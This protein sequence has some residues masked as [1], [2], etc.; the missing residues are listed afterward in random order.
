MTCPAQ[1]NNV[2]IHNAVQ[3][4]S[5]LINFFTFGHITAAIFTVLIGLAQ[6]VQSCDVVVK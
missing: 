2:F 1:R 3:K 5:Y 6:T 4:K